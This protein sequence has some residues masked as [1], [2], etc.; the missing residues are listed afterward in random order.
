M[1]ITSESAEEEETRLSRRR[2]RDRARR[3]ALSSQAKKS[4]HGVAISY[5]TGE[6]E[7]L[8]ETVFSG[9]D[10]DLGM[11]DDEE[12]D[13]EPDLRLLQV[14]YEYYKNAYIASLGEWEQSHCSII[15]VGIL[16]CVVTV[17]LVF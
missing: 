2:G 4:C 13:S 3:A 17:H 7:G 11:E 9:S 14:I 1:R 16:I 6:D 8:G 15:A 5:F 12:D 10:D